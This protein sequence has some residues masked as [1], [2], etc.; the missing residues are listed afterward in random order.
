MVASDGQ[1]LGLNNVA[2]N[3]WNTLSNVPNGQSKQP[4][5]IKYTESQAKYLHE[6]LIRNTFLSIS[7]VY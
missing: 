4:Q 2:V 7:E 6:T 3:L 5:R 1:G